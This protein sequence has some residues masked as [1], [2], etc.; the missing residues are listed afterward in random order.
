MKIHIVSV[1]KPE[2]NRPLGK[3]RRR[4]KDNIKMDIRDIGCDLCGLDLSGS[5][6]RPVACCE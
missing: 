6:Y 4:W 2:W 3:R 5:G 1:R